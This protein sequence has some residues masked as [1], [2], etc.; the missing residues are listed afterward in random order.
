VRGARCGE[1]CGNCLTSSNTILLN[2]LN[3]D[4][5]LDASHLLNSYIADDEN[6]SQF[7]QSHIHSTYLDSDSFIAKF[8]NS[9][10]P[11]VLS[12][13]IQSLNSKYEPLKIFI[14]SLLY[15]EIPVDLIILQET[16][17]LKFPSQLTIPGF[18]N[19]IY[20][21]RE[22]GRGGGVGIYI[23]NGL[24]FKE[25]PDLE[26]YK[27]KTFENLVL[28]IQYPNKSYLISNIYI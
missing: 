1:G 18:Q 12:I 16:W 11:I 24:N 28:E 26:N 17:E 8:K 4:I 19:I 6:I 5:S 20:R 10:H 15:S 21:T 7:F 27:L 13:N 14:Q 23:R 2:N 25:R 3:A 9:S 22:R